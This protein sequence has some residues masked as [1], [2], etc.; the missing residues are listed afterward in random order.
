M[1]SGNGQTGILGVPL[2]SAFNVSVSGSF[3]VGDEIIQRPVRGAS[4]T[5]G[6]RQGD[7]N[8]FPP[9]PTITD[10]DGQTQ[11]TLTPT[12]AGSSNQLT[13]VATASVPLGDGVTCTTNSVTFTATV[14]PLT[15][16][17]VSGNGQTGVIGAPLAA[18]FVVKVANSDAVA[19][20]SVAWVVS[21][22][23]GTLSPPSSTT[24]GTN[25]QTQTTLTP[26]ST[27]STNRV[28]VTAT[29]SF[30]S[31]GWTVQSPSVTFTA[32]V[33]PLTLAI[34]SGN[35]QTGVIGAPL[36]AAFVVKVANSDAVAGASVAWVVSEGS[37]TLSPPSPT[38]TGT[39]GQTQTTLTPTST[40]STNRVVVTATASFTSGGRTVQSPSVT[41]TA[42]VTPLSLA[43]VSGDG[44]TGVIGVPLAAAFVVKVTNGDAVAGASVTW[45][46]SQGSG[47]LSPP[48]PTTTGTNGQTQTTLTPTSTGSTNQVVVT[49][50]AS[51]TSGGRTVQSPSLRFT[52]TINFGALTLSIVSGNGQTGVIGVPLPDAFVV[53]VTNGDAVAGASVTWEF[54]Q[55]SGTFSPP[56][57]TTTGTNGQA[58]TK[59]TP[60]SFGNN[61]LLEVTARA[62]FTSG[63]QTV[64]SNT[65]SFRVIFQKRSLHSHRLRRQSDRRHQYSAGP[66]PGG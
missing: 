33:T 39:N 35:G 4:V 10:A 64:Q 40:G 17:I 49:A 47:T 43:M 55:G 25:G 54:S 14:T 48:S 38:T 15:L 1:G 22:G 3:T 52:A 57:P 42:T 12:S 9:S 36:A 58:Q 19:G 59:L 2:N 51:F 20:A 61:R 27:G 63:G 45:E 62:S 53:K 16:A 24:T 7:G 13:V 29:A 65:V 41:F 23:S 44:Q 31:G 60:T 66:R 26:T 5:W 30:T 37:G 28:V 8:F 18:A 6:F 11:T 34:V 46:F 32:T 50:T 56:S 21:E